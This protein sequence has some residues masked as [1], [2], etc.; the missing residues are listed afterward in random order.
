VYRYL[1]LVG[2]CLGIGT[3]LTVLA[4]I[5]ISEVA[6]MGNSVSPNH[7]WIELFNTSAAAVVVDDWTFV[8]GSN[9]LI[10]LSGTIPAG[11]YAVLERTSEDSAPGA[12]FL[13]YTGA[14]VNTGATL[15]LRRSDGQIADQVVGGSNW[16]AIG[17]DNTTKATAQRVGSVWRTA[18]P[19]P[20]QVNVASS[21]S[22]PPE[23]GESNNTP[24]ATG[25]SATAGAVTT[26]K[27]TGGS[28]SDTIPLRP[29]TTE[30]S[31]QMNV[32]A[33][34][35]ERQLVTMKV[36]PKGIGRTIAASLKYQWNFGDFTIATGT[37][38]THR[39]NHPGTY[40]VTVRGQYGRHDVVVRQPITILPV[41]L[42]VT[43]T[44]EVVLLNNDAVYD[45]DVSGFQLV[46]GSKIMTFPP[47]SYVAAKQSVRLPMTNTA[48]LIV[49][50]GRG[51]VVLREA[52]SLSVQ[53]SA[54]AIVSLPLP[55]EAFGQT[56]SNNVAPDV[57][58]T[59]PTATEIAS[60]TTGE[61]LL[62]GAVAT[63]VLAP[64]PLSPR[65]P[66]LLLGLLLFGA[67][68]VVVWPRPQT[69]PSEAV[70]R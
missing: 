66:Y 37:A 32:P 31:L 24:P 49:R 55:V 15:T 52:A 36:I 11:A 63:T 56:G 57:E 8:D 28:S 58:K 12:A 62:M 30:L 45:I 51:A 61:A 10:T 21:G 64:L 68:M 13:V 22:A 42:S 16:E 5:E 67:T 23:G 40:V 44:D 46:M 3:P 48:P 41:S 34:A 2:I 9:L 65:W 20:G 50:D 19:T 39:F 7:E 60:T 18:T 54:A 59:T 70:E 38:V 25:S 14:L 43:R 17:G 26:T 1:A 4:S 29:A 6:W 27:R 35:Y 47:Y 53:T 69:S 33:V